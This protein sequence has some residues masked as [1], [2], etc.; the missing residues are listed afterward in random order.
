MTNRKY[1]LH[2]SSLPSSTAATNDTELCIAYKD[3]VIF[4][5]TV[6]RLIAEKLGKRLG[7]E[8]DVQITKS[9]SCW[10]LFPSKMTE[11]L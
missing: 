10:K 4:A 9:D 1:C 2:K 6:Q 8:H 7:E 3:R 5:T 11:I